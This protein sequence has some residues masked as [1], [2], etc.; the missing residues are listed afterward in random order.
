MP[1]VT[2]LTDFGT[3]DS[4]VA[5]VRGTLLAL[6]PGAV[7]A[8]ITH[9]VAPGDIR[10]GAFVLGRSWRAFPPG[11]VHLAVVDPGVGSPRRALALHALG[12]FFVGPDN[13]L[14]TAL[15][16]PTDGAVEL[17]VPPAVGATFHGRDLFAPAAA[18]LARGAPLGSLGAA[19]GTPPVRLAIAAPRRDAGGISGEV[20]YVDR[21]GTLITNLGPAAAEPIEC[22][23]VF[24]PLGRTFSDAAA[25]GLIAFVGSGGTLEIAM[26]DGS[27]AER[28]RASV[29]SRVRA[30]HPVPV[31]GA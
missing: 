15:L 18:A 20:V 17:P 21:F 4:Y 31:D 1:V 25:G 29:G 16:E 13:G 11:T 22:A 12:H 23:G 19:L 8:D 3:R 7:L 28:L 9:E 24:V 10:A 5:E 14:F 30:A 2:L 6:A 26:R 27:A